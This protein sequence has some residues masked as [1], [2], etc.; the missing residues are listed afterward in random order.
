MEDAGRGGRRGKSRA[1]AEGRGRRPGRRRREWKLVW[2]AGRGHGREGAPVA[3]GCRLPVL[4]KY[5][6]SD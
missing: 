3:F 2:V 4:D 5:V 6:E 1:R